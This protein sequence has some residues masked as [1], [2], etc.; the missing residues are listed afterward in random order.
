MIVSK[1]Q[2]I[3]LIQDLPEKIDIEEVI[4]RLYL[5]QK[6]ENAEEDIQQGR[7]ITHEELKKEMSKWSEE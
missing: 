1:D 5:L 2:V 6:L 4:Y 3:E 7:L